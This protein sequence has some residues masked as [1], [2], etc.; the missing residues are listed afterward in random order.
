[1]KKISININGRNYDIDLEESFANFL[2][3]RVDKDFSFN[4]NNDHKQLLQAYV[5]INHEL[6][7]MKNSVQRLLTR[8]EE[9]ENSLPK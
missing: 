5:S 9:L 8:V 3:E 4:A 7:E 1:M 2:Q 6:F